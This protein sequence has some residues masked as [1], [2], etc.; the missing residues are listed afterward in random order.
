MRIISKI[1]ILI[2]TLL[3]LSCTSKGISTKGFINK[4]N[5]EEWSNKTLN[6]LEGTCSSD[7]FKYYNDKNRL[8]NYIILEEN[9]D[10]I[11]SVNKHIKHYLKYRKDFLSKLKE[12]VN[13]LP[14]KAESMVVFE[15]YYGVD[16]PEVSYTV[17]S[18]NMNK[19][20]RFYFKSNKFGEI[21]ELNQGFKEYGCD[22][23][24]KSKPRCTVEYTGL[25]N[26]VS[27]D[28]AISLNSKREI[29]YEVKD[30]YFGYSII[31]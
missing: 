2:N 24:I 27:F 19:G 18:D 22:S 11:N 25:L 8:E 13:L 1:L 20:L 26:H 15:E 5:L 4:I 7:V 29:I 21:Q 31:D 10:T 23:I 9:N 6:V 3:I 17:F 28:T 12:K 14:V 30:S 16:R